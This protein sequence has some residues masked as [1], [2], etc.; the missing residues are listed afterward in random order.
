MPLSYSIFGDETGPLVLAGICVVYILVMLVL[1][2]IRSK[3]KK[4]IDIPSLYGIGLSLLLLI[5]QFI[6]DKI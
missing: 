6:R 2:V 5:Y 4:A 3:D 1:L